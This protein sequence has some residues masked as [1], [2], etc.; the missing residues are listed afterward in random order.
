MRES[1]GA[2]EDHK[3]ALAA[4]I[5]R[6]GGSIRLR[7][8]G[9]SMLPAIWPGDLVTV[10]S[11]DKFSPGE[12]VMAS[13]EG[14]LFI[15]RL[16]A[17]GSLANHWVMRGDTVPDCDPPVE[18]SQLLGKVSIIH[19]RHGDII[20]HRRISILHRVIAW[21]LGH[22]DRLRSLALQLRSCP[23]PGGSHAEAAFEKLIGLMLNV[24]LNG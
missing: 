4:E 12:I 21:I 17:R 6:G 18:A 10:E 20:P 7:V 3:R 1:G 15:H 9:T 19:R 8:W 11:A 23:R 14:R 5:L 24:T 16:I 2:R 22:S 13:Q